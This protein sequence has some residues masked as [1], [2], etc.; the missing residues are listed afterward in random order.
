[1]ALNFGDRFGRIAAVAVKVVQPFFGFALVIYDVAAEDYSGLCD[2][3]VPGAVL[4]V[5]AA[6]ISR[7]GCHVEHRASLR[8]ISQMSLMEWHLVKSRPRY[9]RQAGVLRQR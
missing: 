2:P 7:H 6:F 4:S 9:W 8:L 3:A 5:F 1:M